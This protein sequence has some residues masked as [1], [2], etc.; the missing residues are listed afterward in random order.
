MSRRN[1]W[2]S[3]EEW[4]LIR[5]ELAPKNNNSFHLNEREIKE[6]KE[7]IKTTLEWGVPAEK[8]QHC[9]ERCYI[10]GVIEEVTSPRSYN[11]LC[12]ENWR[13]QDT[14]SMMRYTIPFIGFIIN[15]IDDINMNTTLEQWED[16]RNQMLNEIDKTDKEY[17]SHQDIVDV[18]NQVTQL[19]AA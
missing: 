6:W 13:P 9:F 14:W 17:W 5:S 7:E 3:F 8:A 15:Y 2:L 4:E 12:R 18:Y 11:V 1:I 10:H 19:V 16:L